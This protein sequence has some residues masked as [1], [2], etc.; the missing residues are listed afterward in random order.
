ME[1][2]EVLERRRSV[3][4]FEP[5]R[6]VSAEDEQRL[7]EAACRAPSAGNVQPWRFFAVRNVEM[8]S[9]LMAAALGQPWVG[10]APLLI[11]ACADLAAHEKAYG[12]RGVELYSIQDTAAAVENILLAA[13]ALGLG[14]CWIG[15]F[16]ESQVA[17]ALEIPRHLRPVALIP[18]GY[19][20]GALWTPPK[21]PHEEVIFHIP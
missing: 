4:S 2:F 16:R 8:K 12:R 17:E 21:L 18:I 11:V 3:R 1:F 9:R 20:R 15:A 19:I 6:A 13:T 5:D 14:S 7:L 10:E